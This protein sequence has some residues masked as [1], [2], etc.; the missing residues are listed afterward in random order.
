[1]D[2][3]CFNEVHQYNEKMYFTNYC[4]VLHI[5]YFFFLLLNTNI[6]IRIRTS[7]YLH[8]CGMT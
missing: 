6:H 3:V 2:K 7:L 4:S 5:T 8:L 1:M